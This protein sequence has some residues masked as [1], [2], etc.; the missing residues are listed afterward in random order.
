M[1][2]VRKSNEAGPGSCHEL[3]ILIPLLG[4]NSALVVEISMLPMLTE[5]CKCPGHLIPKVFWCYR[6]STDCEQVRTT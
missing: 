2:S 1:V 6:E 5:A 3:E 4:G